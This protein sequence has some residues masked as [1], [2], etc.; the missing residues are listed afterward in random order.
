M[1]L[2]QRDSA[3]SVSRGLYLWRLL[4]F[5]RMTPAYIGISDKKAPLLRAYLYNLPE[6]FTRKQREMI[7]LD[8][9]PPSWQESLI[10]GPVTGRVTLPSKCWQGLAGHQHLDQACN[11]KHSASL[12]RT[13]E[14]MHRLACGPHSTDYLAFKVLHHWKI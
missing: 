13:T 5:S 1:A 4:S 6:D 9:Q 7:L 14:E 10:G 8:R 3:E 11:A 12:S 2:S